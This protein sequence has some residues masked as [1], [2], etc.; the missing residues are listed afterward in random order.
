MP[1]RPPT[2]RFVSPLAALGTR[3][4]QV[5][6]VLGLILGSPG[7]VA[8]AQDAAIDVDEVEA[9]LE[10]LF[11]PIER[12]RDRIDTTAF[13]PDELAFELAFEDAETI[14]GHVRDAVAFEPYD[15]VLRGVQGTLA[16]GAGNAWDQALLTARLLGDAGYATE[17]RRAELSDAQVDRLLA[18]VAPRPAA[19][20]ARPDIAEVVDVFDP[21]RARAELGARL[22]ELGGEVDTIDGRLSALPL[23]DGTEA[24]ERVRAATRDYAWVAYRLGDE[25]WS[26]THPALRDGEPFALEAAERFDESLPEEVQHRLRYQVFVERKLGSELD[27]QPVTE[28]WERPT[29][30]MYGVPL[31]YVSL[32]DGVD[33]APAGAG[34]AEVL[35][36]TSFIFPMIG[37]DIAPGGQAFDM[38][39]AVVPMDAVNSPFAGIFQTVGGALGD[40]AGAL[41]G[42]GSD[43]PADEAVALSAQWIEFT[44]IAPGGDETSY[45]RY[46]VDRVGAAAR[47]EGR[48]D[49]DAGIDELAAFEAIMSSHTFML[50]TGRYQPAYVASET[51]EATLALEP[52]VRRALEASVGGPA[53]GAPSA[54]TMDGQAQ[55]AP[56]AL[57]ASFDDAPRDAAVV[58]F[59]PAP[60]LAVLSQRLDGTAAHVDV[61]ANPRWSLEAGADG[62]RYDAAATRRYGAWETRVEGNVL[63]PRG[64]AVVPAVDVLARTSD[65]DLRALGPG[66]EGVVDELDLPAATRAA[67]ADDLR[68]GYHVLAPERTPEDTAAVGWWRVDPVTGEALGRGSDGRGQALEYVTNLQMAGSLIFAAGYTMYSVD[69]CTQIEDAAAAGCCIVQQVVT[70]GIGL[71]G[72]MLIGMALGLSAIAS[73]LVLDVA[74]GGAMTQIPPVCGS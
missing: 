43:E 67:V 46:V 5:A 28:A 26:E 37:D 59:R 17:I 64:E 2:R 4:V 73:F 10:A 39:G 38:S 55:V 14:V 63:A 11:D 53:P 24:M 44:M 47:N 6:V 25:A 13:D 35:D 41:G 65:E 42:L 49:L 18:G 70:A 12:A 60:A 27:A 9:T 69:Q 36:E 30:N 23:G 61:V 20:E 51:A 72:G 54:E 52:Y 16:S 48:A 22:D 58:S 56:L 50:D 8:L 57:F 31:T 3:L 66:D 33:A 62:L 32:P 21:E 7:G 68:R 34:P 71:A 19:G 40:A 29:A 15:G 45:R 1:T 74:A